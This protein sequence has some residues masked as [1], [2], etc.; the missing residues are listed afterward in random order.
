M[1]LRAPA[2]AIALVAL[3]ALAQPAL[4]RSNVKAD[5]WAKRA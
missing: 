5:A 1:N 3:S 4:V 2:L